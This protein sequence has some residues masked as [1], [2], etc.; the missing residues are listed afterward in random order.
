MMQILR[1]GLMTRMLGLLPGMGEI[2]KVLN[3]S[4]TEKGVKRM[5][6]IIDSMTP[7]ERRTPKIIDANRRARIARG[8]GTKVQE[9]SDIIK[10]Y[11]VMAPLMKSL[12]GKSAHGRLQAMQDIQRSG[13]MNPGAQMGKPKG[14]TGKKLTTEERKKM[15]KQREKELR[16]KRREGRGE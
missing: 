11:D 1:P 14:D 9:V 5:V 4:D 10:Q 12:A 8:A 13:M 2:S 15:Q 6:G 7:Q 16:K 3:N